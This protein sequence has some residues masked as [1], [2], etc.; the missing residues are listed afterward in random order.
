LGESWIPEG[1]R[2]EEARSGASVDLAGIIRVRGDESARIHVHAQN[3]GNNDLIDPVVTLL[4]SDGMDY[5][6]ELPS[7]VLG[8][9]TQRDIELTSGADE[10]ALVWMA[11]L[12]PGRSYGF[13][14]ELQAAAGTSL[15]D[16]EQS[17]EASIGFIGSADDPDD[18]N[19]KGPV[20]TACGF[21]DTLLTNFEKALERRGHDATGDVEGIL[22]DTITD[23]IRDTA[24]SKVE[25]MVEG[26]VTG[27]AAAA[28]LG[29]AAPV[30]L[31]VNDIKGDVE[32]CLKMYNNIFSLFFLFP[33]DPNDKVSA[34][35]I[36]GYLTGIE[37]LHYVIHFENLPEATAEARR[38]TITD[39]IDDDLDL[40]SFELLASSHPIVLSVDVDAE[41]R[42][43]TFLFDGIDLPPNVTAP[44]GQG[45]V[46]FGIDLQPDLPS[47]TE[48]TNGAD[49][50]FDTQEPIVTPVVHHT[51]DRDPPTS[52]VV[53]APFQAPPTFTLEWD[54]IDEGVGVWD[55]SVLVSRNFGEWQVWIPETEETSAV[56]GGEVDQI[57]AFEVVARDR[58]GWTESITQELEAVIS[59][60]EGGGFADAGGSDDVGVPSVYGGDSGGCGCVSGPDRSSAPWYAMFAVFGLLVRRRRAGVR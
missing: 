36:D 10:S 9:P 3:T 22:R 1:V 6:L 34:T 53:D 19:L 4:L 20:G 38:V 26:W 59:I 41:T 42:V 23:T 25:S 29:P 40:G 47:G 56:F 51:I 13:W 33:M 5:L 17:I 28:V 57:Y 55:Y 18:A 54:G 16:A 12:P 32:S 37:T 52:A 8:G 15:D 31:L 11:R 58:L 7:I 45:W 39:P 50:I 46:E 14:L 49:I 35:G 2:I 48:I 21:I 43:I 27:M 60:V 30:A 44:G 24:V